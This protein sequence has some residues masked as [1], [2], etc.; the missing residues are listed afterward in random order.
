MRGRDW[1]I[2]NRESG[3]GNRRSVA[4]R[5]SLAARADALPGRNRESIWMLR[6]GICS[7]ILEVVTAWLRAAK[8]CIVPCVT[9]VMCSSLD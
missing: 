1:G 5:L 7:L 3:I 4:A 2:G 8:S 9:R 6:C